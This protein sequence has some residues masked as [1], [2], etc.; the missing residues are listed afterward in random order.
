MTDPGQEIRFER[1]GRL[2]IVILDRPRALNALTWGMVR[3]LSRWLAVWREDPKI[4]AV[5]VK[6]APGRAFCAGGDIKAVTDVVRAGGVSAALPFFREEYRLNWRIH[7]FPK[8]YVAL[9]DGFTFGG[10]VGISVHGAVRVVTENTLVAMPETAIGFFPDV[11]ATWFLPR[12]PGE[13]GMYLGL[14]G[15]R[16][17]GADCLHAGIGTHPV[18]ASRLEE[19]E[20]MLPECL[21]AGEP[22]EAIAGLLA[23]VRGDIGEAA[24]PERRARIDHCFGGD[25]MPEVLDR[26]GAE[27]TGF[28]HEQLGLLAAMSPLAVHIAFAQIRRGRQLG[29]DDALRLE[30]R[31]VHRM[32]AAPDFVEGVR[33]LLVDKDK[34]PSWRYNNMQS[35]PLEEV[36]AF[37]DPLPSGDLALDWDGI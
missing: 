6:A 28:G 10:G 15:A 5:L 11:G 23:E 22:S 36:E 8:P 24:L 9:L 17:S 32:L 12:C 19:L 21:E 2:G 3:E 14:T 4:A 27:S 20:A 18:P 37:M 30:Y 34:R 31:M 13:V 29:I 35:V 33:A 7:S 25:T 16:L 26:L 1:R